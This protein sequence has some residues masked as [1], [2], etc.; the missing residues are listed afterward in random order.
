MATWHPLTCVLF[1]KVLLLCVDVL[2]QF[3]DMVIGRG[4]ISMDLSRH[5]SKNNSPTD[6]SL[7]N[8][9]A[10]GT[11]SAGGAAAAAEKVPG[12]VGGR[13][14]SPEDSAMRN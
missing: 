8:G 6:M 9:T 13:A 2:L 14:V 4:R 12:S 11:S 5:N 10:N 7:E 3:T 1:S